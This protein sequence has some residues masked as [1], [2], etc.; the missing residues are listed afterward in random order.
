MLIMMVGEFFLDHI[1]DDFVQFAYI[2][3]LFALHASF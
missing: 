3:A 1:N 2:D